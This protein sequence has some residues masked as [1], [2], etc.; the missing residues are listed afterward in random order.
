VTKAGGHPGFV[1]L[2]MGRCTH[3]SPYP[4]TPPVLLLLLL[5]CLALHC[6]HAASS[7]VP[8]QLLAMTASTGLLPLA[9]GGSKL[10]E[11]KARAQARKEAE[12]RRK[13][14]EAADSDA[15]KESSGGKA[16][17]FKPRAAP[18]EPERQRGTKESRFGDP[19]DPPG[20]VAGAGAGAG[21]D[22]GMSADSM[23]QMQEQLAEAAG[24]TPMVAT[25]KKHGKVVLDVPTA[26]GGTSGPPKL[27]DGV[28]AFVTKLGA[29]PEPAKVAARFAA[30]V[31]GVYTAH[32]LKDAAPILCEEKNDIDPEDCWGFLADIMDDANGAHLI[33]GGLRYLKTEY[34]EGGYERPW[35][36]LTLEEVREKCLEMN[37]CLTDE[38]LK[39][40]REER[41]AAA[42]A[43]DG[44]ATKEEL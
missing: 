23:A 39:Q 38:A 11:A 2:A 6:E 3:C 36:T 18:A 26:A 40:V 7:A 33:Q 24:D 25:V 19:V 1:L 8:V 16:R 32:E 13:E 29:P 22:E 30:E 31:Y 35:G 27:A 5:L 41:Q 9:A 37:T 43:K 17:R 42:A 14:E 12:Q 10:E 15:E 21:S 20:G 44:E 28:E 34:D 4:C